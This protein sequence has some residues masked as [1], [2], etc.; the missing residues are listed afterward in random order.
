[1]F[2]FNSLNKIG[3]CITAETSVSLC[4]I[5]V[6]S[7]ELLFLLSAQGTHTFLHIKLNFFHKVTQAMI[8]TSSKYVFLLVFSAVYWINK[9]Q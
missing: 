8:F 5:E 1:M 2:P 7:G 6:G 9:G 3:E 4:F